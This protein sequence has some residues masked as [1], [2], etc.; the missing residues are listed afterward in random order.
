MK[1]T[2]SPTQ[3]NMK[4][5]ATLGMKANVTFRPSMSVDIPTSRPSGP[6]SSSSAPKSPSGL[7][8]SCRSPRSPTR[9]RRLQFKAQAEN[10]LQNGLIKP[11][12]LALDLDHTLW[13]ENCH[14][15]TQGPYVHCSHINT[16][17]VA[18]IDPRTKQGRVF[19][20]F[21][22]VR[23]VLEWLYSKGFLLTICSRSPDRAIPQGIL[24]ALGLWDL[25][26]LPQIY[27]Q[28]KTYHFRNLNDCTDVNYKDMLFFDDCDVNIKAAGV[29]GVVS[30]QVDPNVGLS[31]ESLV[32]GLTKFA[33][34]KCS[35]PGLSTESA[36]GS[37][38]TPLT[39]NVSPVQVAM[40]MAS[41]IHSKE[42]GSPR[43]TIS[44]PSVL[45]PDTTT[46]PVSS[47]A[48]CSSSK[49]R[50]HVSF[51]LLPTY[52]DANMDSKTDEEASSSSSDDSSVDDYCSSREIKCLPQNPASSSAGN[53]YVYP[54]Q[55]R[56][57]GSPHPQHAQK[58]TDAP[59]QHELDMITNSL[60]DYQPVIRV[61][62]SPLD[63][64]TNA[65]IS[66]LGK[67]SHYS[68]ESKTSDS[69][70]EGPRYAN[71]ASQSDGNPVLSPRQ[72]SP[73]QLNACDRK[74]VGQVLRG[75][76]EVMS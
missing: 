50:K 5:N 4:A 11:R 48:C 3:G 9:S 43:S 29:L 35:M 56:P 6:P 31:W 58:R 32:H 15:T 76:F 71:L 47:L 59:V 65:A 38:S 49:S 74:V 64:L 55:K 28:R 17:T 1:A 30:Y 26:I 53:E 46:V 63:L 61:Q 68:E 60:L 22:E 16:R 57:R 37:A 67:R 62:E 19:S 12:L 66:V 42:G 70:S 8:S 75:Y 45:T 52:I 23:E 39:I 13:P 21:Y 2:L 7:A 69:T 10:L 20:M 24:Q 14:E 73:R 72:L 25:F 41:R 27:R 34:S 40:F 33:E 18:C 51:G 54:L 44:S 36:S